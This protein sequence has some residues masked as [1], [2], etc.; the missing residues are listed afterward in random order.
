MKS[1]NSAIVLLYSKK[2]NS[3]SANILWLFKEALRSVNLSCGFFIPRAEE[4]DFDP[5]S[6]PIGGFPAM[7]II[8]SKRRK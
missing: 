8:I 5:P 2:H 4:G 3:E 6:R 7:R 1:L